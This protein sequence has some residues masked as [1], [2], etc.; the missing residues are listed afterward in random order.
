MSNSNEGW[1]GA[2]CLYAFICAKAEYDTVEYTLQ[3]GTNAKRDHS[4]HKYKN[5]WIKLD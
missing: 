5:T 4:T 1:E 2:W 3:D